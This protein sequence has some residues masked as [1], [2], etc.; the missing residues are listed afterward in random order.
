MRMT[1]E[2]PDSPLSDP[3]N[4]Q[5]RLLCLAPNPSIDRTIELETLRVGAINRPRA[6][7]Q[8]AGGKALN[9]ARAA[10][11]LGIDVTAVALLAGYTGRWL[12]RAAADEDIALSASW[13][14]G[15]TRQCT[16]VLD[17]ET[18][19][20]TEIYETGPQV[21]L[22]AWGAW[23]DL[24]GAA[25]GEQPPLALISGSLLPGV[26]VDGLATVCEIASAAGVRLIVDASGPALAAAIAAAP[27]LVKVNVAEACAALGL[28]PAVA[29]DAQALAA[30]IV[31]RGAARAVV[32][33]G[34][35]GSVATIGNMAWQ[36]GPSRTGGPYTVGSGDAFL[37][38]LAAAI[39]EG[40]GPE[41]MLRLA[42]GAGAANTLVPGTGVFDPSEARRISRQVS[43]WRA[44]EGLGP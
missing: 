16:S 44:Q 18:G 2:E 4:P 12:E 8:K 5:R 41:E 14:A 33:L 40:Q 11:N 38:G 34:R 20:L 1:S 24:A 26:P 25:L 37:G 27:W 23:L 13:T 35:E 3:A 7:V 15:E 43:V 22:V 10:K 19:Q 32:T 39:L 21:D 9:A 30:E 17:G 36:A 29:P 28:E 6:V 42:S 31:R